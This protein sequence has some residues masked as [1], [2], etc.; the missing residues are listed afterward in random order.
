MLFGAFLFS[1]LQGRI[2]E[3]PTNDMF[4]DGGWKDRPTDQSPFLPILIKNFFIGLFI[5]I[6]SK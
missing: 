1:L 2:T 3:P 5:L 4:T 6:S